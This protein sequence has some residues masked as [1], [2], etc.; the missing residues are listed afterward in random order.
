MDGNLLI[1]SGIVSRFDSLNN[2]AN[3]FNN[4]LVA[5]YKSINLGKHGTGSKLHLS[6]D[7][8]KDFAENASVLLKSSIGVNKQNI[9][10]PES[11]LNSEIPDANQFLSNA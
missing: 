6:F 3:E 7:S 8:V 9:C 4:R 2:K 1:V 11:C 10:L 5:V